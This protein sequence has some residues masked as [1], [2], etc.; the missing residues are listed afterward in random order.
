MIPRKL[1]G[2]LADGC[3][4]YIYTL[5]NKAGMTAEI[6]NY[7][8]IVVSLTV[9]DRDG[10]FEDVVLGYNNIESYVADKN[11]FGCIVGRY[12][13]RIRKG[14]FTLDGKVYQ[15]GIN[16]GEHHLHG[17]ETGFYKRV[18]NAKPIDSETDP[19]LNLSYIS[20]DGEE[21]YPGTL[22]LS[23]MY[24]L[25]SNNELKIEYTGTTDKTTILNPT[26]HSY[27]NLSGDINISILN[28]EME[29]KADK[30]IPVD[31]DLI[32]LGWFEDVTN[33]PLDFRSRKKVDRD[34]NLE[35]EQL[36]FASGYD[37]C[38]VINGYNKKINR[39]AGLYEIGSGRSMEVYSDQPGI[40][41]YS[42]NF[43]D[44]K[45]IGK[46]GI[47]SKQRSGLCL[48]AQHYP[49][50][51]NHPLFPSVTLMPGEIYKQTTIY[52]FSTELKEEF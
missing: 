39:I 26:H 29:I 7:G 1:F 11:F 13:N 41:F 44:E 18:W 52:K 36:K 21:G 27:F 12:G 8:A 14:K 37:H 15:L 24:T 9:P 32:P 20:K 40:Q 33:T 42:G 31:K 47:R 2:K 23:V 10:K 49:D 30:M 48:E 46:K 38:W 6:I 25:T 35:F 43:L 50:S 28:H 16:N 19:A 3:E 4:V 22:S 45:I 51:P 17:G 5:K 34:I